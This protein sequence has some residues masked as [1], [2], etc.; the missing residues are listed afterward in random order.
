MLILESL[1]V[2]DWWGGEFRKGVTREQ[3]QEYKKARNELKADLAQIE[4][5][6]EGLLGEEADSAGIE[7]LR[8]LEDLT[9]SDDEEDL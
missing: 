5:G 2:K 9:M 1:I 8:R 4:S 7:E 3:L 6:M